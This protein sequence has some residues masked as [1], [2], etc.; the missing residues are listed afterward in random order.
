MR[1]VGTAGDDVQLR[2][3]ID[4]DKQL[5]LHGTGTCSMP[6]HG[7]CSASHIT[8]RWRCSRFGVLS[9]PMAAV[10]RNR[11]YMHPFLRL[12]KDGETISETS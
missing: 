3:A 9:N 6:S 8:A 7:L 11:H 12:W 2:L 10:I 1:H 5:Q 4:G